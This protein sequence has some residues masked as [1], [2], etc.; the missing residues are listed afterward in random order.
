MQ[1][2]LK[3]YNSDV[4][5]RDYLQKKCVYIYEKYIYIY[6]RLYIDCSLFLE[7]ALKV[8]IIYNIILF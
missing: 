6:E 4:F 1:L 7:L 5:N 3:C 2:T 8:H